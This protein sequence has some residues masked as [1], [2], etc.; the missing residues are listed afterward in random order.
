MLLMTRAHAAFGSAVLWLA[1]LFPTCSFRTTEI[2]KELNLKPLHCVRG[3]AVNVFG[4][5]LSGATVTI[6]IGGTARAA[7]KT[8]ANGRFFF[9]DLTPGNYELRVEED[10]F[11]TFHFPIVW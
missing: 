9:S 3:T 6:F 8:G 7:V 1:R 11:R 5:P 4:E 10:G 2:C